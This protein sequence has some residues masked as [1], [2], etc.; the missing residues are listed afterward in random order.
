MVFD[1]IH[2][3]ADPAR[4][5]KV[6]ADLFPGLRILATGSSTLAAARKFRDTLAGR[7]RNVRLLPVLWGELA[8]FGTPLPRRLHAG[9][10]PPA[11]LAEERV[12]SFYR[13]WLDSFFARDIQRLFGFRDFER[14]NGLFE[15]V[16]RQSGGLLDVSAA[17]R[18]LGVGRTTVGSHLAALETTHAATL[19]RPFHGGGRSELVKMP[20]VYGFDAGFVA[21]ARGWDPPRQDDLGPLWEHVVLEHLQATRPDDPVRYWRTRDGYEIDFVVPRSRGAVDAIECRWN[22]ADLDPAALR[23]FRAAYPAGRI[24]VVSPSPAEPWKR[25][26][27]D[28]EVTVCAPDGLWS[29][30]RRARP[31][32][33]SQIRCGCGGDRPRRAPVTGPRSTVGR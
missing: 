6:G 28:V 20:K 16:L 2:Q 1:E 5:L 13:E 24:F 31:R 29:F 4:V 27:G 14:F 8:S 12:P 9:G 7:K 25:A 15:W 3:I 32:P 33:G 19:V 17:A 30:R 10:L 11:A 26:Y 21:F 18:A 22:P 23:K